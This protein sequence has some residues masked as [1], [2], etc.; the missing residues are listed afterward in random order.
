[1][2]KAA[3][4]TLL[5][6]ASAM[7][8]AAQYPNA[9]GWC[10]LGGSTVVINNGLS[11]TGKFQQSFPQCTVTVYQTGTTNKV[12]IYSTTTG[13]PLANPFTATTKGF[14]Q[15]YSLSGTYDVNLSGG[16][17][18]SP[19]TIPAV[20]LPVLFS[21]TSCGAKAD[22]AG[23][24]GTNQTTKFQACI[25]KLQAAGGG[26]LF[27]PY[28]PLCYWVEGLIL[29]SNITLY[30]DS[31]ATCVQK[32]AN[33]AVTQML[34]T[35]NTGNG[36]TAV[37]N[38]HLRNFT[39]DGNY[40]NGGANAH[41]EGQYNIFLGGCSNCS[42]EHMVVKNA[43]LDGL[44]QGGYGAISV[45]GVVTASTTTLTSVSGT[46]FSG[47][48]PGAVLTTN[49]GTCGVA[50]VNHSTNTSLV[51]S[52]DQTGATSYS[53]PSYAGVGDY[54][55]VTDNLITGNYRVGLVLD[56]GTRMQAKHNHFSFNTGTDP[57]AGIDA[58]PFQLGALL[59]GADISDNEFD[60]N[61]TYGVIFQPK[62]T[63]DPNLSPSL[64]NNYS[65]DNGV[66]GMYL[67]NFQ[68]T[69]LNAQVS[70]TFLN[71]SSSGLAVTWSGANVS[72][73]WISASGGNFGLLNAATSGTVTINSGTLNGSIDDV[74]NSGGGSPVMV[75]G[76]QLVN[77]T[78]QGPLLFPLN[79]DPRSGLTNC[80]MFWGS[81]ATGKIGCSQYISVVDAGG[82]NPG[83]SVSDT[84]DSNSLG[85][86]S[87]GTSY[88]VGQIVAY[89]GAFYTSIQNGTNHVPSS[90][91]TF[92]AAECITKIQTIT[93]TEGVIGTQTTCPIII[94]TNNNT[95]AGMAGSF[96][97]TPNG[98]ANLGGT[99]F[100][101]LG[102]CGAATS[103]QQATVSD[104]TTQVYGATYTG[105][106]ALHARVSCDAAN[107]TVFSH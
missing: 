88:T 75:V 68:A 89:M 106:G 103:N 18:P 76:A 70:G 24:T 102:G 12:T 65:H 81:H 46:N 39:V 21:V 20:Q 38:I 54:F 13:T 90:S 34:T 3:R 30:S 6:L 10:E 67:V 51:C 63:Y 45:T 99:T 80:A 82:V 104:S 83:V 101:V 57:Q 7:A 91:P 1:M 25:D 74:S 77:G 40:A 59:D 11:S 32:P 48:A 16:G 53:T 42:V 85:T 61:G 94:T 44:V 62:I 60:H 95:A 96:T 47:M 64:L 26:S 43:G 5:A 8:C 37:S 92:W 84:I 73:P 55:L 52:T 19:F 66:T 87:S 29:H 93:Q 79:S 33:G 86:W 4:I 56:G 105:G 36:G 23:S 49:V 69:P 14:W 72:I 9:S 98:G 2:R 27:M 17:F 41:N 78:A 35:A 28:A 100:S 15:F 50:S 58:E 97:I 31:Q 71:N 22:G 107:W